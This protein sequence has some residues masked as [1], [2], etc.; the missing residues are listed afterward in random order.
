MHFYWCIHIN[1]SLFYSLPIILVCGICVAPAYAG[2]V[3]CA[4]ALT[5]MRD[6]YMHVAYVC[7]LHML[8]YTYEIC[9]V[10]ASLHMWEM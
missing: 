1:S 3:L 9:V 8:P 10:C 6:R 4:S 5:Y 7:A 2:N